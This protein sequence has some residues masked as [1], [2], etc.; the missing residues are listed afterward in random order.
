MFLTGMPWASTKRVGPKKI[1]WSWNLFGTVVREPQQISVGC[2][3]NFQTSE[4]SKAWWVCWRKLMH[5]EFPFLQTRQNGPYIATPFEQVRI[6]FPKM[7]N[8]MM[9]LW[10]AAQSFQ[11]LPEDCFKSNKTWPILKLSGWRPSFFHPYFFESGKQKMS[12]PEKKNE[13]I[14]KLKETNVSGHSGHQLPNPKQNPPY[15]PLPFNQLTQRP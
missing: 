5:V 8:F 2:V 4:S 13:R 3:W 10:L 15:E 1:E 11:I 6:V 12:F 9:M 14:Q 7:S